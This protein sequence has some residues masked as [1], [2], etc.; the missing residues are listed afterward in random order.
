MSFWD[1]PDVKVGGDY[2]KFEKVGDGVA[3]TI[4]SIRK[5]RFDDGSIVPQ[6]LLR[7]DEDEEVTLTVGQIRLKVAFAEQRPEVGDHVTVTLTQ[8]EK[9]A[10]GR[11]LKH[12]D[13]KV[14]QGEDKAPF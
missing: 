8:V 5:H 12:F 3:G 7:T 11:T 9:R 6:V 14:K 10:G 4:L 1:D 2:V 13:V